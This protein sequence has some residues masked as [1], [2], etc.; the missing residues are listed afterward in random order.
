MRIWFTEIGEPLPIDR[1]VRLLRYGLLSRELARRGHEVT[2][3][4]SGFEHATHKHVFRKDESRIIDRVNIRFLRGLGY[5]SNVSVRRVL[6]QCQFALRL[7]K[8]IRSA[9]GPDVIVSSIPTID[10][11]YVCSRYCQKNQVPLVVDIR[12]EWPD[13]MI[14][15][16]PRSLR[17]ITH[18][19][20]GMEKRRLRAALSKASGI[21]GTSTRQ[22]EY[23]QRMAQRSIGRN[24]IVLNHPYDDRV[25]E[26]ELNAGLR[27]WKSLG[28]D[29][30]RGI[31]CFM[32]TIGRYFNLRTVIEAARILD[33]EKGYYFIICGSGSRIDEVRRYAE[34]CPTVIL[35]GWV[36]R[37]KIAALMR[38]AVAGLAPYSSGAVTMSMP[39]KVV[40]Y[41]AGGLPVIGSLKGDFID[42]IQEEGCGMYYEAAS[43]EQFI[44]CVRQLEDTALLNEMKSNAR[45]CFR[46]RFS[47]TET[48]DR[49][50][51]YLTQIVDS[52]E[53]KPTA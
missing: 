5:S 31:F 51:A 16:L 47:L 7:K 44:S 48:C 26:D 23:G 8:E 46:R 30:S 10:A 19:F 35:P 40:E 1:T 39:N 17:W 28:V 21:V 18:F 6:H 50:E 29:A 15:L 36:D 49:F 22:L 14:R 24:N 3:W 45:D 42:L 11:A 20:F 52:F 33:K 2:W 41:L 38:V 34:G 12:D 27:F 53:K 9:E 32:G 25:D 37:S 4:T 43:V 13:D